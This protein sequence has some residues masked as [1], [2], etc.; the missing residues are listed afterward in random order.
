MLKVPSAA[1]DIARR[2]KFVI[3]SNPAAF[4]WRAPFYKNVM[5]ECYY[6]TRAEIDYGCLAHTLCAFRIGRSML[7]PLGH[8]EAFVNEA[9][10][11]CITPSPPLRSA[12]PR[13]TPAV[14]AQAAGDAEG[15][16]AVANLEAALR[17]IEKYAVRI[18]EEVRS[19][20]V[21]LISNLMYP[22]AKP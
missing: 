6:Y 7:R 17:P 3:V 1:H 2:G 20:Q 9:Q 19:L 12:P 16:D 15:E 18:L 13:P 11:K 5:L 4:E 22:D 21:S 14:W 8:H 10:K